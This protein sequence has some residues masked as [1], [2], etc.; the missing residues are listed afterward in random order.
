MAQ[1]RRQ[2]AAAKL[3]TDQI[4]Q[5]V[6]L[7]EQQREQIDRATGKLE[8]LTDLM[9]RADTGLEQQ[10]ETLRT[11]AAL[12]TQLEGLSEG[13]RVLQDQSSARLTAWSGSRPVSRRR[14]DPPRCGRR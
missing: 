10:A 7:L 6:Q 13:H 14:T 5:K 1:T 3:T 8:H 11:A 12:R 2:V 9:Q 4:S